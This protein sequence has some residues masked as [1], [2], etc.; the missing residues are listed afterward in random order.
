MHNGH[1]GTLRHVVEWFDRGGYRHAS[2]DRAIRPLELTRDEKRDLIAFL[3][4]L[5]GQMPPVETGRLPE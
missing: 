2:L 4:A 3:E 5:T 1:C